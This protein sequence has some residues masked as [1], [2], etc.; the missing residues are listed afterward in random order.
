MVVGKR[1]LTL[2]G[3]GY[4]HP[5]ILDLKNEKLKIRIC[6]YCVIGL[7]HTV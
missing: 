4:P 2:D 6:L 5:Y 7:K 3:K 1:R